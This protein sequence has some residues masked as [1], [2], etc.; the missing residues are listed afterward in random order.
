MPPLGLAFRVK[1][2]ALLL[3]LAYRVWGLPTRLS[4]G[5]GRPGSGRWGLG[6]SAALVFRFTA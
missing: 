5:S 4:V 3:G 2:R 1:F 6:L